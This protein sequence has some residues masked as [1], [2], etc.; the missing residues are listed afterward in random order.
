MLDFA[1]EI[2]EKI[3]NLGVKYN[4]LA[5]CREYPSLLFNKHQFNFSEI[6]ANLQKKFNNPKFITGLYV[7]FPFCQSRCAF[8]K[9]YSEVV[10]DKD[11]F[12]KYLKVLERELELYQID[13]SKIELDNLCLGGGTPTLLD[14]QQIEKYLDIIYRFFRLKP[15]AQVSIEGTPETIA[16]AKIEEYKRLGINRISLG[17]QSLND[18]VLRKIGRRHTAEDVSR[19]F[20]VI[21]KSGIK[22]I[23]ADIIWGLP[24]ESLATYKKTISNLIKLSPEFVEGFLLTTGG[25]VKINRFYP[26]GIKI[27]EIISL[28]KEQFLLNGYRINSSG[29]FLGVIKKGVHQ[30]KAVNQNMDGLYNCR[31]SVLGI[32]TGAS[33]HFNNLKYKIVSDFKTYSKFL[34]N[35]IFPPLYGTEISKNDHKRQY[36]ISRIGF[37]RSINKERYYKLFGKDLTEDF[38][39]EIAYLKN[40]GIIHETK[41]QYKW[42]L[43]EQEMGHQ[44]FFMHA[45]QYWYNPKYIQQIVEEYFQK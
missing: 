26:P 7:H 13:F 31:S 34:L 18:K 25:R 33:S 41:S 35:N 32:G 21:R 29:N 2:Y 17:L 6:Q 30:S 15:G 11:I 5:N 16:L 43:D 28:Y 39:K 14:E 23:A 22:Y 10:S 38:L 42:L 19:A 9:Y 8:C 37:F 44:A 45:I 40:K 20:D 1:N 12:N 27:D 36:I 4:V 24:G 3:L